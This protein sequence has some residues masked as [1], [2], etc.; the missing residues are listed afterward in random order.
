MSNILFGNENDNPNNQTEL[1][2]EDALKLLV[3]EGA[4]YA[5]PE[6]MA[7]AMIHGQNHITTLEAEATTFKDQ[8]AQQSSIDTILEAIKS[9]NQQP[10]QKPDDNPNPA[11]QQTPGAE[12]VDIVQAVQDAMAKQNADTT[13]KG[14]AKK[15]LDALTKEFGAQASA[16]YS[17][18]GNDLGVDLDKLSE[19]SPEAVIKL[20]AGQQPAHHITNSLPGSTQQQAPVNIGGELT[21]SKINTM[22]KNGE[23]TREAKFKLEHAQAQKLGSQFFD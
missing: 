13:A 7:K 16:M 11:D 8:Q 19:Q 10:Q 9:G 1:S 18:V 22:F 4:K 14:N 12:P 21:R 20:V 3:G 15:V 2:G 5:T 23:L 17:K 6:E